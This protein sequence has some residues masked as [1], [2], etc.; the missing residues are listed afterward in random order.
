MKAYRIGAQ[1]GFECLELVDRPDPVATPGWV[2]VRV[3]AVTLNHRDL[4][5]VSGKY[6]PL[7]DEDRIPVS[8]GVGTIEAIGEDVV[9]WQA[10]DRVICPHFASWISGPFSPSVFGFDLGVT[11]DGWLAE[12]IA[13]PAAALVRVPDALADEQVVC[14][15]AAGLTAWNALAEV[16]RVKAGDTVLA[17]G[18]GGV[19]VFA[20]QIAKMH[21]ARVIITSSSDEKL[22]FVRGLGADI[23]INYATNKDWAATVAAAGGADVIVETGGL[24]TLS[25]SIAAAAPNARVALIGALGTVSG[26]VLPNFGSILGKNLTLK[27]ITE[28]SRAML[29]DLVAAVEVNGMRPV[30]DRRFTF[31]QA[32]EAYAY[33]KTGA[34]IGKVMITLSDEAEA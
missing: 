24:A 27:G 22:D 33:L 2:V 16:G 5:I 15:P 13:I 7:R 23:T 6:G 3:R 31:D 9:G 10:G 25:Q 34:H 30:I 14:L 29:A 26:D 11:R 1:T 4:N 32:A 28:G 17:L 21:G 19:S 12:R 8:D 18:T 20:L